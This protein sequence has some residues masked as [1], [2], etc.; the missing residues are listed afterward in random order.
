YRI[1]P[2]DYC[3]LDGGT[4]VAGMIVLDADRNITREQKENPQRL[5]I[6]NIAGYQ[7]VKLK[8]LVKGGNKF[9]VRVESVKG[10]QASAQSE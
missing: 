10:G 7:S 3:Y 1:D 2:P 8:W 4:V 6:E 5:E 9:T